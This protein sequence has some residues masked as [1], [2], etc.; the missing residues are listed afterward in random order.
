[1]PLSQWFQQTRSALAQV[2]GRGVLPGG[3][4]LL[5]LSNVAFRGF[6]IETTFD[7]EISASGR[8]I[9]QYVPSDVAPAVMRFAL[10]PARPLAPCWQTNL[11]YKLAPGMETDLGTL[12]MPLTP[13]GFGSPVRCDVLLQSRAYIV[14]AELIVCHDGQGAQ[15]AMPP[16][17]HSSYAQ[18]IAE[19]NATHN[20]S[21]LTADNP[22]DRAALVNALA[23]D[24][25]LAITAFTI[26]PFTLSPPRL[27]PKVILRHVPRL[28][29]LLRICFARNG[30]V[31]AAEVNAYSQHVQAGAYREAAACQARLLEALMERF[32]FLIPGE[33]A[34]ITF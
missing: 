27:G 28:G 34:Q 25:L 7:Y 15:I 5:S 6:Q 8:S 32:T 13:D 21:E 10:P 31:M 17:L 24:P 11:V 18:Q 14:H 22:L 20:S 12:Q 9:R 26:R 16:S 33:V 19:I 2:S 29:G 4:D 1:M 3:R 23:A 30:S